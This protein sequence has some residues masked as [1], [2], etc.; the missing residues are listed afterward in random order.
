MIDYPWEFLLQPAPLWIRPADN[1]DNGARFLAALTRACAATELVLYSEGGADFYPESTDFLRR[2]STPARMAPY[3]YLWDPLDE[4][5][6]AVQDAGAAL[7]LSDP[8]DVFRI[9]G[10][11][12]C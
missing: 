12:A 6:A 8:R 7:R 11:Q 5:R 3:E 10:R 9:G 2:P 4:I 1:C